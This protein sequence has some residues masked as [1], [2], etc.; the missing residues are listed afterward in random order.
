MKKYYGEV[1]VQ[2]V[3][4]KGFVFNINIGEDA[5]NDLRLTAF[6]MEQVQNLSGPGGNT[7]TL[8]GR[9]IFNIKQREVRKPQKAMCF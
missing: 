8:A 2:Q 9:V 3:E 6:F 1:F 7:Y 4:K 5:S